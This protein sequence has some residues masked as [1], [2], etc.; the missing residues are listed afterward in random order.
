VILAAVFLLVAL[1]NLGA[2]FGRI[3][4]KRVSLI[5]LVG[6][7]AG[8]AACFRR[9]FAVHAHWWWAPPIA[10]LGTGYLGLATIIFL[11]RRRRRGDR[12]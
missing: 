8:T 2:V 11:I 9:P 1:G 6:G 12:A 3:L 10:D 5:P 7:L 4:G